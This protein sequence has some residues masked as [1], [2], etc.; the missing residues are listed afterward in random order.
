MISF[1]VRPERIRTG[2]WGPVRAFFDVDIG[3]RDEEGV[4][5][6]ILTVEGM[7]LLKGQKGYFVSNP[8]RPMTNSSGEQMKDEE[9]K[10]RYADI[11]K[12][13]FGEDNKPTKLSYKFYDDIA[14]AVVE[15]ISGGASAEK[16]KYAKTTGEG[17]K[18]STP[19][20][21][22]EDELG[23]GEEDDDLPF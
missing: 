17:K 8:S 12:K 19:F 10:A 6:G 21:V 11:V 3:F 23:F 14:A 4:F 9:G 16:K 2:E 7:R 5:T 18:A 20:D 1:Q 13:Y 22:E 15:L